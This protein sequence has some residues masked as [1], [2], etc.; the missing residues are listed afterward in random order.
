MVKIITNGRVNAGYKAKHIWI[1]TKNG[2]PSFVRYVERKA[3][4]YSGLK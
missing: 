4:V 3:K 2:T 1:Q